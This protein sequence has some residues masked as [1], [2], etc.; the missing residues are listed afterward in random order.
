M[1]RGGSSSVTT[2]ST[3]ISRPIIV[4]TI[5]KVDP[6]PTGGED[7]SSA[8]RA[9]GFH[10]VSLTGSATNANATAGSTVVSITIVDW[11][12][13]HILSDPATPS[14]SA[15]HI[16]GSGRGSADAQLS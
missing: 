8:R 7:S 15:R 4:P 14:I 1:S 6:T 9:L 13:R 2:T 12:T 11:R 3:V 16:D 5:V 10:L